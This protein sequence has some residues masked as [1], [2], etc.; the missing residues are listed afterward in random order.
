MARQEKQRDKQA[1][2]LERKEGGG[3]GSGPEIAD[4]STLDEFGLPLDASPDREE[5]EAT[6]A[7]E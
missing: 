2:R 7:G 5:E 6:E 3:T 4:R 1:K